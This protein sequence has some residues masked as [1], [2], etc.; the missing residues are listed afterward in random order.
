MADINEI[1]KISIV[2]YLF[3]NFREFFQCINVRQVLRSGDVET[4]GLHTQFIIWGK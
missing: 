4:P 2:L 1:V 3:T